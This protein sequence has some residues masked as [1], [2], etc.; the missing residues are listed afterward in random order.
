MRH[1]FAPVLFT[2][3]LTLGA[4]P[5]LAADRNRDRDR[6]EEQDIAREAL[7]RGEVLPITRILA[8]VAQRVPGEV[9]EVQLETERG[10]L[11]YE[12]K[13]LTASGVVREVDV[14]A[15]TGMITREEDD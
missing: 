5:A 11:S 13:V 8:V 15:R 12:V 4:T 2:L 9:I 3:A 1:A 7:R 14:D 10:V 6:R